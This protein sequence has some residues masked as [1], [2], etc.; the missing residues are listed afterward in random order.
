[1]RRPGTKLVRAGQC[2]ADRPRVLTEAQAA[3]PQV[4]L[5]R[6]AQFGLDV[7]DRIVTEQL[8]T[9]ADLEARTGGWRGALTVFDSPWVAFRR[10]TSRAGDIPALYLAGGTTHP[11]GGVPMVMLSGKLAAEAV[12]ADLRST[13]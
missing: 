6:F 12:T 3:V 1:M 9:P 5:R 7:R 11:G 4:V 2:A 10:P 8:I 13:S